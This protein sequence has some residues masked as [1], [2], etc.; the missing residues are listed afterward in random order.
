MPVSSPIN[1]NQLFSA[2]S[3]S[4]NQCPLFTHAGCRCHHLGWVAR[5]GCSGHRWFGRDPL[6]H[7]AAVALPAGLFHGDDGQFHPS[8][9]CRC[10]VVM[11]CVGVHNNYIKKELDSFP[12][13][14][15]WIIFKCF[16]DVLTFVFD[17][18]S[19]HRRSFL[20]KSSQNRTLE[21]SKSPTPKV[22]RDVPWPLA[23]GPT[24]PKWRH[25][26]SWRWWKRFRPG[27]YRAW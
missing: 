17:M 4:P 21:V 8:D 25:R 19:D 18:Y 3:E 27:R 23:P 1:S 20:K 11:C 9:L 10:R 6:P 14:V 13:H 26:D 7:G 24:C 5:P 22:E 12:W 15:V 2:F 16:D